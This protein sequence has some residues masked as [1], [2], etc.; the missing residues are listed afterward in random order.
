MD[1]AEVPM[2]RA[3]VHH[4][5]DAARREQDRLPA[6]ASERWYLLGVDTA[7]REALH[8]D[9]TRSRCEHWPDEECP[10]FREGYHRTQ[11]VLADVSRSDHV[12]RM[13]PI[14]SL[15]RQLAG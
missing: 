9:L 12:P 5:M 10:E 1:A 14:P 6:S 13:I 2:F 7:A 11:A 3:A 15:P 4:L 8:P